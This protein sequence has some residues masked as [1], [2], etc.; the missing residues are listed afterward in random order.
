MRRMNQPCLEDFD[1][2]PL[3]PFATEEQLC[4]CDV[5]VD[6]MPSILINLNFQEQ[7]NL[8]NIYSLKAQHCDLYT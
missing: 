5:P 7:K 6:Q 2:C 8:V 3:D 4:A 1:N